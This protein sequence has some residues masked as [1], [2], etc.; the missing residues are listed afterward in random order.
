MMISHPEIAFT[1]SS[2]PITPDSV[3][4]VEGC[5]WA[6]WRKSSGMNSKNFSKAK[7]S[8]ISGR[9]QPRIAQHFRW[10]PSQSPPREKKSAA[11]FTKGPPWQIT[12]FPPGV[13]FTARRENIQTPNKIMGDRSPKANQKKSTQK[14]SKTAGANQQ[15]QN[16]SAAKQAAKVAPKKK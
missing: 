14:Q 13:E 4:R 10:Y 11:L 1:D 5:E 12:A 15:K 3:M 7:N 6:R 16:V 8:V 2:N 9:L